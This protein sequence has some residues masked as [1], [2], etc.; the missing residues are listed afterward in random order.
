MPGVPAGPF[1]MRWRNPVVSEHPGK[2]N[3]RAGRY[4]PGRCAL[5]GA[6]LIMSQPTPAD[7]GLPAPDYL[8][9]DDSAP[10]VDADTLDRLARDTALLALDGGPCWEAN[11]LPELLG[12]LGREGGAP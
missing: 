11:H 4:T 8:S 7:N 5:V 9:Y 1:G 3:V 6:T 2:H 12:V 10:L